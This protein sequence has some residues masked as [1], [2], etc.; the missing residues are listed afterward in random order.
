MQSVYFPL[1]EHFLEVE[2]VK[3]IDQQLKKFPLESITIGDAG[4]INNCK[5]GR[6]MEDQPGQVPEMLNHDLSIPVLELYTTSKAYDFFNKFLIANE[7]QFVR[8]SQFN[9]LG[10]GSFVGRHLDIDS[11]PDYQIAAVLQLGSAF[12]GGDFIVYPTRES[13]IEQA[14]IISPEYGSLT[15]S[16]CDHEHEVDKVTSGVRTSFVCFLSNSNEKNRR[17]SL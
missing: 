1:G 13:N 16:F 14:Q 5:V 17:V 11:N 6:L 12:T 2:D 8:R 15:I 9:L 3:F 7:D 10:C 4:E